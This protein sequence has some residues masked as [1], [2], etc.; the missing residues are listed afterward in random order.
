MKIDDFIKLL[1]EKKAEGF[2]DIIAYYMDKFED[3]N[4]R[5]AGFY[6]DTLRK[7]EPHCNVFIQKEITHLIGQKVLVI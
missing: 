4:Y 7:D 5:E 2:T 3:D 6:E 1:E